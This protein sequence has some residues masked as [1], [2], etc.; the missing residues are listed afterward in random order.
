MKSVQKKS[1]HIM[2]TEISSY[3]DNL[4]KWSN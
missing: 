1:K 2:K 3:C 4:K